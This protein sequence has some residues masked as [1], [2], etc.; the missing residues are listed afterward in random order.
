MV[1]LFF[2]MTACIL[3]FT[4]YIKVN[5]IIFIYSLNLIFIIEIFEKKNLISK[6][7]LLKLQV[8]Q[9]I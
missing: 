2:K 5:N 6:Y 1:L 8:I 7:I 4:K 3:C 9:N